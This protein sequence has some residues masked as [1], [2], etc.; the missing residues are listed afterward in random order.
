MKLV[1]KKRDDNLKSTNLI[2][3]DEAPTI[4]KI[5]VNKSH[6]NKMSH[7]LVGVGKNMVKGFM[8]T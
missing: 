6:K 4:C 2:K 3:L 8:D 5:C 7:S 1:Q